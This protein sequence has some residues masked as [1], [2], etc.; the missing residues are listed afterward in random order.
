DYQSATSSL[1]LALQKNSGDGE[2][3][4]YLAE[5]RA[6]LSEWRKARD[7]YSYALSHQYVHGPAYY[8]LGRA[9]IELGEYAA[10]IDPLKRAIAIQPSLINAHF[11]LAKAY[12]RL[13][14]AD[15]AEN[16]SIL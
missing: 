12:R 8:G 14:R 5:S 1:E 15:D 6:N 16:E 11:Q 13:K 10:A 4:F 3:A 9:Q 7:S 2:A